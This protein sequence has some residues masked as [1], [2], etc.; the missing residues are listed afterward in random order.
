MKKEKICIYVLMFLIVLLMFPSSDVKS[1][2]SVGSDVYTTGK[3]KVLFYN[4]TDD[5]YSTEKLSGFNNAVLN[6]RLLREETFGVQYTPKL[7]ERIE[8]LISNG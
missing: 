7:Q 6:V 5:S 3:G 4:V 1:Y 2:G 8:S